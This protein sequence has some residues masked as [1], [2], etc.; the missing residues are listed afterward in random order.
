[1]VKLLISYPTERLWTVDNIALAKIQ[2]CQRQIGDVHA[3]QEKTSLM[4]DETSKFGE[5][6][7]VYI[8]SDGN[9]TPYCLGLREMSSKSAETV[10]ETFKE[11]LNDISDHCSD[12]DS[13][14]DVGKFSL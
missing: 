5:K 3:S 10:F 9:Q 14:S 12:L 1:M 8:V 13:G 11:I 2:L 6:Y 4:S 7:N